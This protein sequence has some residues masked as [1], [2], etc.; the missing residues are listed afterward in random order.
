M[1]TINPEK[2]FAGINYGFSFI[3]NNFISIITFVFIV[4]LL[5]TTM[6]I[7]FTQK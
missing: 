5:K 2:L 3:Y 4:S 7:T 6:N 1:K